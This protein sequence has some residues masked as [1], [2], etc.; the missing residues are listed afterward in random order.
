MI[1]LKKHF[2]NVLFAFLISLLIFK[3]APLWM[4]S[5]KQEGKRFTVSEVLSIYGEK[6][7]IPLK[8]KRAVYIF[9]ATWCGPCHMQLSRFKKAVEK[10][11]LPKDQIIAV[12]LGETLN[13]VKDFQEKESYPFKIVIAS[14]NNSWQDF[15][16]QATPSTAY[17]NEEGLI[18]TF[19]AGLSPLAVFR[20]KQFLN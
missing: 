17:V 8:D 14:S 3:Q 12:N 18:E 15:N 13:L 19:T 11:E 10:G 6:E 16:V 9:W 7:L 1:F 4:N 5:F 20:A 2:G